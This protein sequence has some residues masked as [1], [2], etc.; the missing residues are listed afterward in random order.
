MLNVLFVL[1]H[2]LLTKFCKT[3]HPKVLHC[4]EPSY[5]L[6][7]EISLGK[8]LYKV[9]YRISQQHLRTVQSPY[10]ILF[11]TIK[12]TL[13]PFRISCHLL[14]SSSSK[15]S[16]RPYRCPRLLPNLS[17]NFELLQLCS[18]LALFL[19]TQQ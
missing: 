19:I 12:K 10:I 1:P 5:A 14:S 2:P 9:N 17:C 7:R 18:I 8:I 4:T 16:A 3:H 6:Y 11:K 13:R 15:C